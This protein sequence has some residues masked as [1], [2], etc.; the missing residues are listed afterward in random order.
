MADC[1]FCKNHRGSDS[2][3][4][5]SP[6]RAVHRVPRHQPAGA[7]ARAVRSPP[8]QSPP[9]MMP[10]SKTG[11]CSG[12]LVFGRLEICAREGVRRGGVSAGPQLQR[13]RRA[14]RVPRASA[15]YGWPAH[16]LARPASPVDDP[17]RRAALPA[18]MR[19]V[20]KRRALRALLAGALRGLRLVDGRP[21]LLEI[22][23]ESG[24]RERDAEAVVHRRRDLERQTF[25]DL[26]LV[27]GRGRV[28]DEP[29]GQGRQP[30]RLQQPPTR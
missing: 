1:L 10:P 17:L 27:D 14:D 6:G 5:D 20:H 25:F 23:S 12:H 19:P 13:R 26:R 28:G 4:A 9:S 22:A 2:S 11:S 24:Q 3:E 8:A 16:G 29:V 21:W 18:A 30:D 7:D 15:S